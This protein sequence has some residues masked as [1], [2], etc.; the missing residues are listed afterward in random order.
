MEGGAASVSVVTASGVWLGAPLGHPVGW[1]Q[2]SQ[3]RARR[4]P[5]REGRERGKGWWRR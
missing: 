3:L 5:E 1:V 2:A 4:L